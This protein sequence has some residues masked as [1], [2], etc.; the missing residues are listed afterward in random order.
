MQTPVY[1]AGL[2][3]HEELESNDTLADDVPVAI[4]EAD[5]RSLAVKRDG[6]KTGDTA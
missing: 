6:S 2:S 3:G 5:G 4:V 1:A